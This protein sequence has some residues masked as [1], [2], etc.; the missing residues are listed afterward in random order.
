VRRSEAE[1]RDIERDKRSD[2][3]KSIADHL[4]LSAQ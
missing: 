2:L 3:K 4:S 1:R